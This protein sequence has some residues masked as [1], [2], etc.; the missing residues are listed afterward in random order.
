M[1]PG[2]RRALA[3]SDE[4]DASADDEVLAQP[5]QE[6]IGERAF[7]S[8]FNMGNPVRQRHLVAVNRNRY[9]HAGND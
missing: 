4:K 1:L 3:K 6:I 9:H 5:L 2:D 7:T 8:L